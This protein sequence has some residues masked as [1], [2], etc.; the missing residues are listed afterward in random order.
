MRE[1]PNGWP[2][3]GSSVPA[4]FSMVKVKVIAFVVA[5]SVDEAPVPTIPDASE[6]VTVT[7]PPESMNVI[8]PECIAYP[9]GATVS[10]ST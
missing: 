7:V 4:V 1:R 5:S 3:E 9:L 8:V 6:F 2:V 10:V